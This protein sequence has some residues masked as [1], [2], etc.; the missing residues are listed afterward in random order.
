MTGPIFYVVE[1]ELA[2]AALSEFARWYAAVHAPHLFHAGFSAC[3]SY[4]AVAG[5]M[6]VVDIY[7]APDWAMFERPAFAQY[8]Q[9]A[10]RDPF[11]PAALRGITSTRTVYHHHPATPLPSGDAAAPL[12]A[13]WITIWRFEG[14][15]EGVAEWVTREGLAALGARQLRL[16]RKGADAPTGRSIRPALA[17][18]AEWASR[19]PEDIAARLPPGFDASQHFTGWRMYPWA[20]DGALRVD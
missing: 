12:D 18:V 20:E 4:R 8:R 2:A 13:D 3:T 19:P 6:P 15:E 1:I 16:L 9:V 14:D 5:T 7:Q 10:A 11:R 17:L